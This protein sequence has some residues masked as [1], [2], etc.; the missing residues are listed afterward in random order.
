MSSNINKIEINWEEDTDFDFEKDQ[1][2]EK[3]DDFENLL[4]E[5]EKDQPSV[6]FKLGDRVKGKLLPFNEQSQDIFVELS[7]TQT[8]VIN[9]SEIYQESEPPKYIPGDTIEAYIVSKSAGAFQL[10]FSL[11]QAKQS[12]RDLEVAYHSKIPVKGKVIK[13]NKGGFDVT[14]FGKPAFCPVSQID[15][16]FVE[17]KAEYIGKEFNFLID[18]LEDNGKN[19]VV[20]RSKLLRKEAEQK[21]KSLEENL[22]DQAIFTGE[23][24]EVKDFGAVIDLGGFTGFI[25]ISELSFKRIDKAQ[26]FLSK[27]EKVRV[28][29]LKITEHEGKKRISLSMKATEEDP[30]EV[31]VKTLNEGDAL[32]GTVTKLEKFGAFIELKAGLEGLI[33]I[34]EMSWVKRIHHPSDLLN[35]G[36]SVSVRVLGIDLE[37]KR[38]SLSLKDLKSD[39]W[40]DIK[41]KYSLEQPHNAVVE[42]LKG[43][44][45]ILELEPGLSGLLP[46]ST[47]KKGFGESYR[48]KCSPPKEIQVKIENIDEEN[49]KILFTLP[50]LE[51]SLEDS[52]EYKEYLASDQQ[53]E[54]EKNKPSKEGQRGSFGQL[55]YDQMK[56]K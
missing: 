15:L 23:V 20:S 46:L 33:H 29:V 53:A 8:A 2:S 51:N 13:E 47:I 37:N 9:K 56:K 16:T 54:Q 44:G 12:E 1:K 26:D 21:I 4:N 11:G 3:V 10:S 40:H 43:F 14:I 28:K 34:S 18:Q 27:G 5:D 6:Y 38:I 42:R 49:R 22:D 25:H 52:S 24:K 50:N 55:L 31:Y 30:W 48:K 45:A 39:P 7:A 32:Q 36:D 35:T 19:I 41:S 17:V